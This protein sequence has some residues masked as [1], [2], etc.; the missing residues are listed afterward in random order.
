MMSQWWV[1]R[2][3]RAV[4]ILASLNTRRPLG[5][6][7]V[8]RD[9]HRGLLV[10]AA[11]Q[12][13]QQLAAALGKRQVA[14]LV[15]H[16]EVE[17]GELLGQA[18]GLAGAGLGLEP[19]DQVDHGVEPHPPSQPDAAER[20]RHRQVRL[21]RP[22][23][24]DQHRV[25]LLVQERPGSHVAHQPLVD[26]RAGEVEPGQLLDQRQLGGRHLVADR[27]RLL[28]R[29]LGL[30][31]AA[32]DLGGW[33]LALERVAQ[34]LVVGGPHADE[35]ELA[36]QVQNLMSFHGWCSAGCRSA[37]SPPPAHAGGAARR[38]W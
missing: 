7:Q 10:E 38:G 5:K 20:D 1:S 24:A 31:Q 36:H 6:Q 3:S 32:D 13:E 28:L 23:A 35:L 17:P 16:H 11:D 21:A 29:D 8:G 9:Q 2:S 4:V 30:Q 37:R 27:A 14:K 19:V 25:A 15:Q 22:G 12:V 33:M 34:H 26:R 18:P